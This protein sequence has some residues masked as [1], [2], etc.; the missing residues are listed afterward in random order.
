MPAGGPFVGVGVG[1][2]VATPGAGDGASPFPSQSTLDSVFFNNKIS[3]N[4]QCVHLW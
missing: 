1:G 2:G 4:L 3:I